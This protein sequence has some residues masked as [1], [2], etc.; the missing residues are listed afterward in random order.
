[1][2]H[3]KKALLVKASTVKLQKIT[4]IPTEVLVCITSYGSVP[5]RFYL[6]ILILYFLEI[7]VLYVF[8]MFYKDDDHAMLSNR[9]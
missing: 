4:Q 7:T 8:I 5:R 9:R 1:M 3:G 6:L 2:W